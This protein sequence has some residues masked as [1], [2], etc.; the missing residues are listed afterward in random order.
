VAGFE[1]K[2]KT[3]LLRLGMLKNMAGFNKT[4]KHFKDLKTFKTWQV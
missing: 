4:T 1:K 2:Q 3:K